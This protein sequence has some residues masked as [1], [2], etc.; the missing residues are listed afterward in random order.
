M[1]RKIRGGCSGGVAIRIGVRDAVDVAGERLKACF[2]GMR[3][4]GER[5]GEQ[6]AP[7]E[8]VLEA[9][10]G[11][12]LGI[13]AGDLDGV[14]DGFG[15]GVDQ[16]GFLWEIAGSECVELFRHG[17]VAFV[18]SDGEAEVQKLLE[19]LADRGDDARRTVAGVEAPDAAGKIEIAIAVHVFE[20]RAFSA[21]S[22]DGRGIGG[23]ARDGGFAAGHESAGFRAG[24]FGAKLNG[25]HGEPHLVSRECFSSTSVRLVRSRDSSLRSE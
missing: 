24:D 23:A 9:D 22:E 14:F 13:R 17:D 15:A 21:R 5:H 16:N 4:A 25:F 18:G 20:D 8:C 11:R 19:L 10:N 12:A 2:V 7:M 1:M 3:L 6:R